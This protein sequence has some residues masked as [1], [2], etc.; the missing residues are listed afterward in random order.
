MT[1]DRHDFNVVRDFAT[2]TGWLHGFMEFMAKDGIVLLAVALLAGWWL[3]RRDHSPRRVA[4]A[5]WSALAALVALALVQPISSAAAEQRPFVNHPEV[6]K[7]IAHSADFGF[8]SDHAT[9]AGAIAVGLLFLSWR[10]GLVTALVALLISFSRVYVGV[11]FPQ[12]VAAGLALG[13]V[14]AVI[15]IFL[16]VPVLTRTLEWLTRTP[17]RALITSGRAEPAL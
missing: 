17:A 16:V 4:I 6:H 13:A 11:H 3:G 15:G 7:L 8:P 14:V 12:D 1:G 10:L 9:V 2:S 5:V